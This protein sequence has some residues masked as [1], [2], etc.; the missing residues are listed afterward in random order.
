MIGLIVKLRVKQGQGTAFAEHTAR[1][2]HT[3]ESQE[4]GNV[5][6]RGYYTDDPDAFVALEAYEDQAAVD[7]HGASAHV[8]KA[9]ETVGPMLD[10]DLEV[11]TLTQVW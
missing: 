2:S 10:G 3:V 6:Y 1:M 11:V 5:F 8:A 7:A 9:M 4:P